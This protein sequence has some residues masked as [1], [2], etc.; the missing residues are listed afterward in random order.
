MTEFVDCTETFGPCQLHYIEGGIS[1]GKDIVLLHGMKF[2]AQTWKDLGTLRIL[3]ESARH[4]MALDLPGFGDSPSC[5]GKPAEVLVDFISRKKLEKPLLVGPSMGGR[6]AL[7]FCLDHPDQ[8]GGLVL[9]GAVGVQENRERLSLINVPSLII[10]GGE[11]AISPLENG[12]LLA[13]EISGASFFVIDGAPHPCYLHQ[14]EIWHREL[15]S[16]LDK[17]WP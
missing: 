1:S 15:L 2:Q 5:A 4:P 8:V 9:V 16:F 7:E 3:G 6:V 12:R 11:D 13:R 17:T 10:W 14:P